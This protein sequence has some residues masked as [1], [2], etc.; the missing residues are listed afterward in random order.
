MK[1]NLQKKTVFIFKKI[2]VQKHINTDPTTTNATH[3]VTSFITH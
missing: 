2:T 1:L 3:T